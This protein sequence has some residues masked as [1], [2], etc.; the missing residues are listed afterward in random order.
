MNQNQLETFEHYQVYKREDGTLW[1]LGRGAM[2]VTYKAYDIN[3]R[4]PVALK[5]INA[6]YQG[7]QTARARCGNLRA[8]D[9]E[10]RIG[11][12]RRE[13]GLARPDVAQRPPAERLGVAWI[14]R[15]R[16]REIL[17]RVRMAAGLELLEPARH[18]RAPV[19]RLIS[20]TAGGRT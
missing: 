19:G 9:R 2:G 6:F 4:V 1:E 17:D 14:E 5:V 20:C 3:L 18:E 15:D 13:I 8:L 7:D 10:R 16:G 12:A 11:V